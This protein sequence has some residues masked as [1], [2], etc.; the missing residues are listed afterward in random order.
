MRKLAAFDVFVCENT[1]KISLKQEVFNDLLV[2]QVSDTD[3]FIFKIYDNNWREF[4]SYIDIKL[5]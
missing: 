2:R 1:G 3:I 5:K 4:V